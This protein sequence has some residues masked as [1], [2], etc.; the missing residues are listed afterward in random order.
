[1]L[2]QHVQPRREQGIVLIMALIVLVALTLGALA[3]TRS[4]YTSNVIAGNLAFQQAATHS[5]DA[6]IEAAVA[7][8]E[9]NNGKTNSTEN[10]SCNS[11]VGSSVLACN[12]T[13]QG[14]VANRQDPTGTQTWATF[15]QDNIES[16]GLARTLPTNNP[17]NVDNAG[18]TVSYVIQRMCVSAGDAQSTANDCTIAPSASSST[19]AGGSSCDAERVNLDSVSQVYYRITVRVVG[20][21][22][23]QSYVQSMVAL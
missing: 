13:T 5:A 21:R 11:S 16:N 1:M 18:N 2:N 22:N 19:C 14:Y 7:W 3:L 20:P 9:N 6:G 23:T 17:G 8:L 4:V 12:H 15:W 10:E